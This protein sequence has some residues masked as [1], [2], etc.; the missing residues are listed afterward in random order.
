[1]I[2]PKH[3]ENLQ[4]L[5]ENTLKNRA[6]YIPASTAGL[7]SSLNREASDRFQLLNGTWQLCYYDS[8]YDVTEAF[9]NG[10]YQADHFVP[11]AV[12]SVWQNHGYD[13]HQYT[14]TL[15]P[16]PVDPP[17]VPQNNPCGAYLHTFT[18]VPEAAAPRVHLNFEGV[19]SCFYVWLNGQYVGYSQ[20]SHMTS[21]FDVSG[22][23][24][25][26][27]NKL[28]VLV[29]K[30]CDGS[31]LEDQD[32]FRMSGIF[33]D[34]Y[35]LK[36]PSEGIRDYQVTTVIDR[37]QACA[38]VSIAFS[39]TA[40][41]LPIEVAIFDGK[42]QLVT[43]GTFRGQAKLEIPN[44]HL[45]NAEQPYLYRMEF[46]CG[47]EV[48]AEQLGIREVAIVDGVVKLNGQ[49]IK[50]HGINRHD[51]DP[52][53]GAVIS[54][55]QMEKDLRLMKEHNINAARTSHYPNAPQFYELCDRY[56]FY[57]MDE[58]DMEAHG[59][60]DVYSRETDWPVRSKTW[61]RLIADNPDFTEGI[62]DRVMR[63][64]ERD[65]NRPCVLF[66]SMGNESGYGCGFEEALRR[67]KAADPT[68]LT[69][70]EG[71]KYH[72]DDREYEFEHIDLYS[73]MYPT[74]EE[75]H[76]YFGKSK[77]KKPYIMC[78]Y[79]HA[80]GNGPGDLFD[81]FLLI[82]QYDGFVGGF[83]WEWCDHAITHAKFQGGGRECYLY[84]G[85][86]GEYPHF[87]SFCLDGLV[88]PDRTPHTGLLEYKN[89]WRPVRVVSFEQQKGE[90]T[91]RNETD[92]MKLHDFV[93]I[94]YELTCDGQV[95]ETGLIAQNLLPEINPREDGVFVLPFM[96]SLPVAGKCYVKLTYTLP[97]QKQKLQQKFDQ[98]LDRNH[99][100][101][102]GHVLGFD[103]IC[104]A[105]KDNRNQIVAQW[106]GDEMKQKE[107][108][109]GD[110]SVNENKAAEE[111]SGTTC[112]TVEEDDR[113]L[114]IKTK[115][116]YYIYHKL[117]GSFAQLTYQGQPFLTRPMEYNIWRAPIDNDV[118][119]KKEW[120]RAN[121]D[122][123]MV[124]GR[125]TSCQQAAGSLRITTTVAVAAVSVQRILTITAKWEIKEAGR[126]D[127]DLR[128]HKDPELPPL[129]RFGIRIFVPQTLQQVTYCGLGPTENY[130]D[131]R[132]S[133]WHQIFHTD[134]SKLY[135]DY[136]RPQENGSHSDCDYVVLRDETKELIVLAEQT[137]SFG[138]SCY[139]QEELTKKAHNYELVPCGDTVF[140]ID[141]RQTGMG[142]ASCGPK[143]K[144]EYVF[145]D[146]DF[147]MRFSV[148]PRMLG[149]GE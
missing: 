119:I 8:I 51:S 85:D 100:L 143:L 32:K 73:R 132:H 144:E 13:R 75:I 55:A 79:A 42:R 72:G 114:H 81:Y 105:T 56:G 78:E 5:H 28:A 10:E 34:V 112:F 83:V 12:P 120:L 104:L 64:V 87:G 47:Q 29:L 22:V 49:A 111:E 141:Y 35:L 67:V 137:F 25:A 115:D 92:F 3:Y 45:W 43:A 131:K 91:L 26:G 1:M 136:I 52:V 41:E 88:Y 113:Y 65:K 61:G 68:R 33:R 94:A 106:L 59:V 99:V 147:E 148:Q 125:D 126:I 69:H 138:V 82:Q 57:V 40:Q 77:A 6:Y 11:M 9:F 31:Y 15:Y 128:V 21:E 14:N 101:P 54:L 98:M 36:R 116:F 60:V 70:Y 135:E 108:A 63:M 124:S 84:G 23:I 139:T 140:C 142:S 109:N 39:Y 117:Q 38:T 96:A 66:W 44:P 48:I 58:A 146:T 107:G 50:L 110:K 145:A 20:V 86:H 53:T 16:F 89:I 93:Q 95:I 46:H 118:H 37:E 24:R 76:E 149:A 130:V 103:E 121:Y 30:W 62:C 123:I 102:E 17:Y 74:P 4:V 133:V 27:E 7:A 127:L 122:R 2:V 129:P 71:A 90:V 19:D 18:Y 97:D 134:V 80:M